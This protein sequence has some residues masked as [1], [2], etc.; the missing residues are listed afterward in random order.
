MRSVPG[1][2]PFDGIELRDEARHRVPVTLLMGSLDRE[3]LLAELAHW[4]P[5]ADEFR[6]IDDTEVV[7]LGTGHWPQF[8]EPA[9]LAELIDVAVR[10]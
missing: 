6:A 5:Y 10:R 9:R 1:R 3:G 2:V 4:G 7:R 8:S